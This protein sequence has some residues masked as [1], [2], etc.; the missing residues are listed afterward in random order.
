MI[1]YEFGFKA[2]KLAGNNHGDFITY[3]RSLG[4]NYNPYN[5]NK[6][7]EKD[8]MSVCDDTG[9]ITSIPSPYARM[10]ITALAFREANCGYSAGTSPTALSADYNKALSHCLDIFELLYHSNEIDL[11]EKGIT[12]EKID[13]VSTHSA[14]PDLQSLL[15][16]NPSL[17][18][19][20]STL[21][22][23]R[24]EY[25]NVVKSKNEPRYLFDFKSLYLF[26]YNGKVFAST[27]P[28]TGFYAK[29]DCNLTH[30]QIN[31]RKIL[32]SDPATFKNLANRDLDFRK[33][34][35]SLLK[36]TGLSK[37][38]EDLYDNVVHSLPVGVKRDIDNGISFE[39]NPIYRKFNIGDSPLQKLRSD[40][41]LFIRPDGLDCSY[42]KYLLY[43]NNTVDLGIKRNEYELPLNERRFNEKL[44]PWYGVNDILADALFVLTYDIN[45]NYT[46]VPYIDVA[47]DGAERKRC[48]LPVKRD[49]LNYLTIEDLCNRLTIVKK[50]ANN[51][52]VTLRV[53]LDNGGET[54]LRRE[55]NA[56]NDVQFPNG[57]VF[58]GDD[59]KPFAFG[60]YPFVKS[61]AFV[62]MYKV[63]FYNRF[64]GDYSLNFY[65][66]NNNA[67]VPLLDTEH[68]SNKTNSINNKEIGVNCEY[69]D[70]K[71][72]DGIEFAEVEVKGCTSLI[73]PKLRVVGSANA[74][75]DISIL[76]YNV[77]I[78]IDLGTSNTYVAYNVVPFAGGSITENDIVQIATHHTT[79]AQEW[80]E[81]TFMNKKCEKDELPTA[82]DK[83]REDLYLRVNDHVAPVDTWLSAQLNEFI[84]SRIQQGNDNYSF[85]IP[86]VINFLRRNCN[87]LQFNAGDMNIP[88]LNF[89]IPFAYYERGKRHGAQRDLYDLMR[90][91]KDFKWYMKKD[92]KGNIVTNDVDKA[93]FN[94]FLSE[95][96]FIVRCHLICCGYDLNNCRL[97]WSY[98]LSFSE[99]LRNDYEMAWLSAFK[100]YINPDIAGKE[101]DYVKYTNESRTPIY[102]CLNNPGAVE[103]LTVLLDIGGGSTDVIGYKNKNVQFVTSFGF[104]GNALYLASSM[105]TISE[106]N[107]DNTLLKRYINKLS[108]ISGVTTVSS[109]NNRME[110]RRISSTDSISTLMNYGFAKVR[111]EFENIFKNDAAQYMLQLHNAAI[112]YHVAQMCKLSSPDELPHTLFLS[113]NGSKQFELNSVRDQMIR[114]IFAHVYG[115]TAE[116]A[117]DIIIAPA[118][119]PKTATVNG[120]LIGLS[121]G[122]L[123]TNTTSQ[124]NKNVVMLGDN[125]TIC[126]ITAA[127]GGVAV[128]SNADSYKEDV[129]KN[130]NEFL[131]LFYGKIYTTVQPVI[132][133]DAVKKVVNAVYGN[134]RL[135]L[136]NNGI[137]TDSF[138]FQY[139]ALVMEQISYN[140]TQQGYAG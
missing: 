33:F 85:P 37:I 109:N 125:A 17:K 13:L 5:K 73:V 120:A 28:F 90:D 74:S 80:N 32:S 58:Q 84:P 122:S 77:N 10:H 139:I 71:V 48:L 14:D 134:S 29:D 97:L 56:G 128:V 30:L 138:F 89:A 42:L 38:F 140:L 49:A 26:K 50:D 61:S 25:I 78:A 76:P 87:R 136:P 121:Q 63:L 46:T 12:I 65:K 66:K 6:L 34:M 41:E 16:A 124:T 112:I 11:K 133:L 131:E 91:G 110:E 9:R 75:A 88:L 47:K 67:I 137:I 79:G 3:D 135:S 45:D 60:I 81:L 53:P 114:T 68:S 40:N 27:T 23:F 102:A 107:M 94:A 95:L 123:A 118:K 69:H 130:V 62:N 132:T 119:N 44:T 96:M 113:G 116:R 108:V 21:D 106:G 39:K 82:P 72:G 20:I 93:A 57:R 92:D 104:A 103:P 55:Y 43:L 7:G 127:N 111:R 86:T 117:D 70:I 15:V 51:Y 18:A 59:M 101:Q 24:D 98:P 129:K 52:V 64:E 126:E 19:Y 105:N 4:G 1:K 35:Y 83:N 99:N 31:G 36:D 2:V 8:Y 115:V 100:E 54:K 22:L